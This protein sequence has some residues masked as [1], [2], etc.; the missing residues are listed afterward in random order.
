MLTF[1][2]VDDDE[3]D[4]RYLQQLLIRI[5]AEM[6]L[7]AEI[8]L[9]N[10]GPDFLAAAGIRDFRGNPGSSESVHPDVPGK[11]AAGDSS[12]GRRRFL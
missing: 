10:S 12:E 4:R 7:N 9:F 2:I 3:Y 11:P 6:N 8:Q 1:A 5:M